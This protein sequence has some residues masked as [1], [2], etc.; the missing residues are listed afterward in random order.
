MILDHVGI[1]VANLDEGIAFYKKALGLEVVHREDVLAQKVRVAFLQAGQTSLEL[2]EPLGE[3]GAVAKFL[4][5]RGPGLHHLAFETG[6][7][8]EEMKR[9]NAAGLPTLEAAP[10]P[11]A[12]GHQVCFLHPKN[13]H[14]TLIELVQ[15]GHQLAP[16]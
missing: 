14:G 16:E 11:G 1:A 5:T 3:D 9:L 8:G 6:K 12:R 4:K 15:P 13:C 10:R 2:L 7:I